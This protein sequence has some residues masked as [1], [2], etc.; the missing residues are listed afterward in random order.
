MNFRKLIDVVIL[1]KYVLGRGFYLGGMLDHL[2]P[3]FFI[4]FTFH[5][6]HALRPFFFFFKLYVLVGSLYQN[7]GI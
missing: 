5:G 1:I 4:P 6:L 2:N 3:M 7:G